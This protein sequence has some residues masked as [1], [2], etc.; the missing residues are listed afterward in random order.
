MHGDGVSPPGHAVA[1]CHE[2]V[3]LV[4]VVV[5]AGRHVPNRGDR[6]DA[7]E[8]PPSPWDAGEPG[9]HRTTGVSPGP[10]LRPAG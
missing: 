4:T 8:S 2:T 3:T 5:Y 10:D 1:R 7:A 9:T 6:A